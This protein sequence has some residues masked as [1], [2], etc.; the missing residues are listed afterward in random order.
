MKTLFPMMAA[1]LAFAGCMTTGTCNEKCCCPD[2]KACAAG[3]CATAPNTLSACEKAAGWKLLWDGKTLDGW[4]GEKGG[5]K[6][7]PAKGWKIEDGVLTV[8]PCKAIKD[9]KWVNLPPEQAALGGGGDLVTVESFKDFEFV[10]DFRLTKAANSGIKYFYDPKLFKGTCEEYQVLDP[11]HPDYDK[12]N[13]AGVPGTHRASALY[14]LMATDNAEKHIKPLGEWNT[15]KIVS[16]GAHVEHWL[17]GVKVLSYERGSAEFR[18]LVAKSKYAKE[19]K[20]GEFWGET[21]AGRIK[22]QDHNDSTV[23]YRN[24]KVRSL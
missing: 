22:L 24:I 8:L 5:C 10:C 21:P 20:P 3:A 18:A 6:A 9:G 11:A 1:A 19:A 2:R 23:S 7:P 15:A 17:N 14:D 16:K 4:V 12:P 13:P